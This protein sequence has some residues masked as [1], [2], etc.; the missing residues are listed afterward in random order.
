MSIRQRLVVSGK[1]QRV[2]FR[3]FVVR[4]AQRLHLTGWV[5]NMNDGTVEIIVEGEEDAITTLVDAC[6]TG[7]PLARVDHVEAHAEPGPPVRG[8]T[9]RFTQ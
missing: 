3:D 5:R 8:F 2:G 7:P 9:K 4:A 6:R 1:V